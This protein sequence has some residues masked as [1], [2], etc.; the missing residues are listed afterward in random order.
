MSMCVQLTI[1]AL[2]L[3]QGARQ[4]LRARGVSIFLEALLLECI[5]RS[6]AVLPLQ[7]FERPPQEMID[8]N[9]PDMQRKHIIV[10]PCEF[11]IPTVTAVLDVS[12]RLSCSMAVVQAPVELLVEKIDCAQE[13]LVLF[14]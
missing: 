5:R 13:V 14:F 11:T 7:S 1:I 3:S 12:V 10:R 6:L 9:L 8:A 4:A 2:T